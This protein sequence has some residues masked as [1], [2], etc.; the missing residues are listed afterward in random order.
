MS[1][2]QREFEERQKRKKQKEIESKQKETQ[3]LERRQRMFS[4]EDKRK[5]ESK[6]Q[7]W[8]LG[9]IKYRNNLPDIPFEGKLLKFPFDPFRFVRYTTT[10]LEKKQKLT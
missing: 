7:D 1:T 6:K 9:K 2:A 5:Q 3:E 8:F 10:S 4:I